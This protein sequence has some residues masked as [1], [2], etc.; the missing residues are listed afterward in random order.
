M[1]SIDQSKSN[2]LH[3]FKNKGKD[4]DVSRIECCKC[5]SCADCVKSNVASD[6]P[7]QYDSSQSS[8]FSSITARLVLTKLRL[9][10]SVAAAG[11][12]D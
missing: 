8:T 9:E 12:T 7:S 1:A 5:K 4:Q 11:V 6:V 10:R 2:R 3:A